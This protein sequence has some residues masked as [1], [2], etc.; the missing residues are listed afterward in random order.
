MILFCAF[1]VIV[2][3]DHLAEI[4][5][6]AVGL[7][8][9]HLSIVAV[10][11]M[12]ISAVMLGGGAPTVGQDTMFAVMMIVLNGVVGALAGGRRPPHHTQS[13]SLPG[14]SAYLSVIIPLVTIALILPS[15]T[16]LD[17]RGDA[18]HRAADPVRGGDDRPVR[19]LH[20]DPDRAS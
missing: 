19:D 2:A 14:A 20:P 16:H 13:Y 10:E 9:P 17:R 12:L 8:D 18:E 5:Q 3:A 7:A 11:V 1:A 15:V 6:R 4:D